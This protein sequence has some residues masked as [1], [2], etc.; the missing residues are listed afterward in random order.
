MAI[1]NLDS[2]FELIQNTISNPEFKSK[3]GNIIN[4]MTASELAYVIE[5]SPPQ[6]RKIIWELQIQEK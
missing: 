2:K 3:L 6:E 5:S 1:K 4:E